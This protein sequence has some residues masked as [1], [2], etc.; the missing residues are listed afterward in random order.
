MLADM[1]IFG[2]S[3][4]PQLTTRI[5]DYLGLPVGEAHI[6]RFPDG[7][8]TVKVTCDV[9]GADCFIVQPTCQP[10]N[11][12]LMEM[13]V[14]ID[15][16]KRA[17]ARRIT[18]V[19]PYFGYARQDRK[20]EGRVPITAKLVA[21]LIERAG[22]HRVLTLDLHA[23]QIQGF[24]DVPV[25][26]L[27]AEVVLAHH[28]EQLKLENLVVASPDVGSSKMAW[29]YCQRLNGR[30]AMVE[31]RR[32]SAEETH[33]QF[34]VGDVEGMNV[35]IVDDMISTGGSIVEAVNVLKAKGALDIY[36]CAT[37]PVLAGKAVERLE[38]APV[39]RVVVTDSVPLRPGVSSER[40]HVVTVA[41]LLGEAMRRIHHNESVSSLF[42]E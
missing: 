28:F 34:V 20:D 7:E 24:F 21:N 22:A 38:K 9:R 6:G 31:K 13:L 16:L 2:G 25:D 32:I 5:A 23:A 42:K 40:F 14:L 36:L 11:D 35:L 4:H 18:V 3:G 33:V 41:R 30:L 19:I 37:H 1:I 12:N 15:C 27:H 39:K 8:I 29:S 26:H 17:S 10:V